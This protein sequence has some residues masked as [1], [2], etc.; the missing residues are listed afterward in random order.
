MRGKGGAA[1]LWLAFFA[2]CLVV[3]ILVPAVWGLKIFDRLQK[4]W[5][6]PKTLLEPENLVWVGVGL[7][8]VLFLAKL[9]FL[10]DFFSPPQSIE[11]IIDEGETLPRISSR[12][13]E[14]G[15]ISS[16]GGFKLAA[17]LMNVDRKL[18][19]GQ[20][21]LETGQSVFSVLE[22]LSQGGATAINVAIPPG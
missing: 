20:Y 11:I 4:I 12:L 8:M 13:Q 10:P 21:Q 1:V 2:T 6:R 22:R 3:I 5:R 9:D 19:A 16:R 14:A 7:V 15:L 18:F 17:R